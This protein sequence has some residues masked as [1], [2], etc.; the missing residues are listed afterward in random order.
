L[1]TQKNITISQDNKPM[2]N[3]GR[4]AMSNNSIRQFANRA[5]TLIAKNPFW[6]LVIGSL[7]IHAIFV[8]IPV[9]PAKKAVEP[10]P[11][12]E[13]KTA[14]LPVV[15]TPPQSNINQNKDLTNKLPRNTSNISNVSKSIFDSLFV[16]SSS[17]K[18]IPPS[19]IPPTSFPN[20][21][22][23]SFSNSLPSPFELGSIERID[24]FPPLMELPDVPQLFNNSA[25][26]PSREF[27]KPRIPTPLG[28]Q[29]SRTNAIGQ[30]DNSNP[31]KTAG[32]SNLRAD[33]QNNSGLRDSPIVPSND[34]RNTKNTDTPTKS[35]QAPASQNQPINQPI[36]Q[37]PSDVPSQPPSQSSIPSN[38]KQIDSIRSIYT[39]SRIT[40]LLTQD[41]LERTI[42]VPNP[43]EANVSRISEGIED[44]EWI[45]A[46][47]N[48][49]GKR[50]SVTF[51]WLVDPNGKIEFQG[52]TLEG[53]RDLVEI[54]AQAAKDYRFKPTEGSRKYRF[55][56][57]KYDFP[58]R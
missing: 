17:N 15:K 12:I 9:A 32:N 26:D 20:L 51:V 24:G 48:V 37:P 46:R 50:G 58:S 55:V 33:F 43:R 5:G 30:I 54:V 35:P 45:P 14:T 39:N 3:F 53:D 38:L 42:I 21:S 40:D 49:S 44:L 31:V 28:S 10:P 4:K 57:A 36:N 18:L 11:L 2:Q 25:I 34:S 29:Q 7:G 1:K 27:V 13:I 47:G 8:L 52:Y 41:L 16:Q 22:P 56:R 19:N 23:N 6:T